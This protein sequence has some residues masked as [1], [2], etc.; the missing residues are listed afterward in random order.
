MI[1]VDTSAWFAAIVPTDRNHADAAR[2][3]AANREALVTTDY[4]V[5]ETVTLLR[6]RG[7]KMRALTFGR[8]LFTGDAIRIHHVS[9][10]DVLNAWQVF[11]EFADKEWSFT[12]CTSKVVMEALGLTQAFA[13][14][15]HFRQFASVA[16]VP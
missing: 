7:E 16:V 14:D 3:L 13:F 1:F 11:G 10:L 12:D 9:K 6:V 8:Q 2:W 4:V 15:H 5:G